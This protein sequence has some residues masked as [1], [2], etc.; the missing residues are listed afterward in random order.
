MKIVSSDGQ[1]S[2]D[3]MDVAPVRV[4]G[5]TETLQ[6]KIEKSYRALRL[7]SD[8]SH[9]YYGEKIVICYS[10]GKDSEVILR[11][12]EE[13]L[14]T[15]FEV[16]NAHTTVDAP[17]TVKHIEK[18]FKRLNDKGIKTT[19]RNRY[20]VEVTMWDLIQKKQFP[21]TRIIRYCC[22][23]LKEMSTK[24]RIGV[25]GVRSSESAN[26]RGREVFGI[27]GGVKVEWSFFRLT[28]PRKCIVNHRRL[29]TRRGIAR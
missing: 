16:V 15:D 26:R 12:A 7:G 20:P 2:I 10:G 13:C 9:E 18:V 14:G 28:T 4:G 19:Y 22:A 1:L 5:G 29:T 11:L 27:R 23:E 21:P 25:L 6:D 8:M 24:N 17:Q 3:N